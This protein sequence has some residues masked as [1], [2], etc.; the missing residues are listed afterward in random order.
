MPARRLL[1]RV[2]ATD[3][4]RRDLLLAAF[5]LVECELE[6]AL[7]LPGVVPVSTRVIVHAVLLLLPLAIVIRLRWPLLGLALAHLGFIFVQAREREVTENLYL[8]LFA[9]LFL[10]FSAAMHTSGRRFWAVPVLSWVGGCIGI[11]VDDYEGQILADMAWTGLVFAGAIPAAGRLLANRL[12]LQRALREKAQRAEREREAQAERAVLEERERIAGD[13][14]DIV[15]HALSGMV[16]QASGARRLATQDPD[17]AREAFAAVESSGREALGELR[18]LLGVL[19]R[20]DEELALAPQ[21]SLAHVESLVR[22]IRAGGLPVDLRI[23]G[24]PAS[25]PSGVDV[26]AYRVVQEALG[27]AADGG[28]A[29]RARVIVRYEAGAVELEIRD[30]GRGQDVRPLLGMRERV[31]LYGGDF[32]TAR[33]RDGGHVVVARLPLAEVTA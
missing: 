29:G 2:R 8:P 22:R 12:E 21:A 4:Q 7:L 19:R 32:R 28:H 20:E 18:R 24:S 3:P 30:D 15:A 11:A 9:I 10:I 17:R 13:L 16:I 23:E 26:T 25:L 14:H 31:A 5:V 33:P 6:A 27:N 1:S